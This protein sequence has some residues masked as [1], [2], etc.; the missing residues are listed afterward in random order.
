MSA[1]ALTAECCRRCHAPCQAHSFLESE[2]ELSSWVHKHLPSSPRV[3]RPVPLCQL[4]IFQQ[5]RQV[6]GGRSLGQ[7]W[8]CNWTALFDK[9]SVFFHSSLPSL[10]LSPASH[11]HGPQP[12]RPLVPQ[13][14]ATAWTP[15]QCLKGGGSGDC[16]FHAAQQRHHSQSCLQRGSCAW[17]GLWLSCSHPAPR[18]NLSGRLSMEQKVG[19]QPHPCFVVAMPRD[20]FRSQQQPEEPLQKPGSKRGTLAAKPAPSPWKVNAHLFPRANKQEH[21][22]QLPPSPQE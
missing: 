22:S 2:Q 9:S 17:L 1:P 12:M 15:H 14:E 19:L 11:V 20:S 16:D 4:I 18:L 6:Q 13:G 3:P 7:W 21:T 8:H 5:H 10:L